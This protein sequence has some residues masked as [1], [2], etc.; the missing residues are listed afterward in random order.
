[1]KKKCVVC[2]KKHNERSKRF[3]SSKCGSR[4]RK[5]RLR[6]NISSDKVT[7]MYKL[8]KGRCSICNSRGDVHE[9]GFTKYPTFHIDHCHSTDKV[10]GLL[11]SECNMG[12]GKFRDDVE[13]LKRAIKYLKKHRRKKNVSKK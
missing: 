5:L 4:D 8:Q 7:E 12:L 6:Y 9:L 11:C 2:G 10:R 13:R 3:C 1:M